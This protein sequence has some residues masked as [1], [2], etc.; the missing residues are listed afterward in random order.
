[1]KVMLKGESTYNKHTCTQSHSKMKGLPFPNPSSY[2][3]NGGVGNK[4]E[5]TVADLVSVETHV[6][7]SQDTKQQSGYVN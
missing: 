7:G 4:N 2:K 1:M 3:E 5:D 6:K